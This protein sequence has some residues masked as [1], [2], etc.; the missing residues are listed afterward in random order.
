[1]DKF[2]EIVAADL[3]QRMQ[4]DLAHTIVVFPNKRAKLYF[5]EYL[6]EKSDEPIWAPTYISIS[7]LFSS[8][9]D[10][11]LGDSIKLICLLHQVY[12][13]ENEEKQSL[14]DFYFWGEMLLNDF[15]DVDKSMADAKSLFRNITE[16]KEM[17]DLSYLTE[18]QKEA[19]S[20]FFGIF[21]KNEPTELK[22]NFSEVWNKL[23]SIYQN[24]RSLLTSRGIAYEGMLYR[25]VVEHLD[26]DHLPYDKYVFVGFNVLTNVEHKLFTALK[27]AGKAI[28]YWD[29]D[30]FYINKPNHEAATF[31]AQNLKDFPSPLPREMFNAFA[32][33]KTIQYVEASSENAQAR[34]LSQWLPENITEV[35]RDTAIVLCNEA[36]LSPVLHSLPE[37]VGKVNVTMGYPLIHTPAYSF[38]CA[39]IEAHTQGYKQG[40]EAFRLSQIKNL[41]NHPFVHRLSKNAVRKYDQLAK[42]NIFY[43]TLEK[44]H[45]D[46]TINDNRVIRMDE[47]FKHLF[48]PA[49]DNKQLCSLM[50][51]ALETVGKT[52][53]RVSEGDKQDPLLP[54]YKESIFE[55]Y[56]IVNRFNTLL[57]E[58]D[59]GSIQL[60]TFCTLLQRAI[61]AM[62]IP[63]HGEPAEGVQIM[64]VIE[65]RNLDFR[66]LIMLSVNEGFM[67]RVANDVSFIPYNLRKAFGLTTIE[68]KISL[69]AYYFYRLLQRAE[70]VT[71]VYNAVTDDKHKGE[72]SRFMLQLL[73]DSQ[74]KIEH[75]QLEARQTPQEERYIEVEKTP[76]VMSALRN[77]FDTNVDENNVLAPSA[78]NA[79]IDCSLKFY[80]KYVAG[81]STQD[82]VDEEVDSAIFGTIFHKAAEDIYNDL[83][84]SGDRQITEEKLRPFLTDNDEKIKSYVDN[85]FKQEFFKVPIEDSVSYNGQQL[86]NKAVIEKF[87]HMLL[88]ID[89]KQTPFKYVAAEERVYETF[90]I[91]ANGEP[92]FKVNIGGVVDRQDSTQDDELRIVDYKTGNKPKSF[93]GITD[94][95]EQQKDRAK[96]VFQIFLYSYILI[97]KNPGK[98]IL[99]R[100]LYIHH[101]SA[102]DYNPY[103][104]HNISKNKNI[105]VPEFS[106]EYASDFGS[107]LTKLL[108]EEIF[109]RAVPFTQTKFEEICKY[110]DFKALCHKTVEEC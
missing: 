11:K 14:D 7:E 91:I 102:P 55:A 78:L 79:Y 20:K 42:N 61:S 4:G 19:M 27:K 69:Y 17:D 1:M 30:E 82:E 56:T 84:A 86:I 72:W 71:L 57:D 54:I 41:I 35:E 24:Y 96:Y 23:G 70:T 81:L 32:S 25:D 89:L 60:S 92:S 101:A 93:K 90:E 10:L 48:T 87:I 109:N 5:N 73:V 68:H 76:E 12:N 95:F 31:L 108:N 36:L 13:E 33:H 22:K 75:Y 34:Y 45:E 66:H 59:L 50:L 110:C 106:G 9:S 6:A 53:R 8:M 62:R 46:I 98:K 21:T 49:T 51:W 64:G 100:V 99:P 65:T 107:E 80:Y 43:P 88:E 58:G 83:T 2:L 77:R 38:I 97:K 103:I 47:E 39:I 85:A 15:N 44:L 40:R 18:E 37:S 16:L 26:A 28:F 105:N 74:H 67:P 3:Y 52:F 63:F 94:L 29:Y 104:Q